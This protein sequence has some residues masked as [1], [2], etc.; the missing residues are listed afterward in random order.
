MTI[1]EEI[2]KYSGILTEAV[3]PKQVGLY[4]LKH[5]EKMEQKPAEANIIKKELFRVLDN[6]SNNKWFHIQS[7]DK[8]T[9][10]LVFSI[11]PM[12]SSNEYSKNL[13]AEVISGIPKNKQEKVSSLFKEWITAKINEIKNTHKGWKIFSYDKQTGDLMNLPVKSA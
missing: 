8:K 6:V 4:I 1:K 12:G 2:L 7:E 13:K 9:K 3:N 5:I 10:T 11:S